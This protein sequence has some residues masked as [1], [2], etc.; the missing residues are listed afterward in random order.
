MPTSSKTKMPISQNSLFLIIFVA[1]AILLFF[2]LKPFLLAIF[3]A[4]VLAILFRPINRQLN[5]ITSSANLSALATIILAIAIVLVPTFFIGYQV[6]SEAK[7]VYSS[8]LTIDQPSSQILPETVNRFENFV[9]RYY[10]DFSI[11][12]LAIKKQVASWL[13]SHLDNI[14]SGAIKVGINLFIMLLTLFY[15][16]KNA[17]NLRQFLI[18]SS[19]LSSIQTNKIISSLSTTIS[20]IAKGS[21]FVSAMQGVVSSIGFLIFGVPNA[22]LWGTATAIAALIPGIGTALITIPAI[23]Y[24]YISGQIFSA[25]GLT[26][27][28][29]FMVG[30]IDNFLSPMLVGRQAQLPAIMV[31]ISVLGGLAY[32]GP[33][34][35]ILGPLVLSLFLALLPAYQAILPKTKKYNK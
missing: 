3:L 34:G 9:Q 23:G 11:D 17:D 7:A 12:W 16:L 19:P 20:A 1:V 35:F 28:A 13:A 4:L 15:L 33:L 22:I 6:F 31:L 26:V 32:F 2:V 30:T 29:L 25:I 5:K 18:S 27:W 21:I 24:L 14:F 10:A 8:Y